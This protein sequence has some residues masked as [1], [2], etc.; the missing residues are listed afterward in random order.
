MSRKPKQEFRPNFATTKEGKYPF[1]AMFADMYKGDAFRF[2]SGDAWKVYT[3][4]RSQYN[5]NKEDTVICTYPTFEKYGISTYKASKGTAELQALGFIDIKSG[6]F[7]LPTRYH[8]SNRWKTIDA[9][10]ASQ[11]YANDWKRQHKINNSF[12]K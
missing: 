1:V 6:G 12:K 9:E 2:L 8:L 5:G 10:Q 4:L 7:P 3:V 11:Q